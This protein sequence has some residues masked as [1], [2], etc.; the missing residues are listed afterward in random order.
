M[1]PAIGIIEVD[2][3]IT[4]SMPYLDTIKQFSDDDNI[5]AVVVRL[6]S[7][8][9]KVG[10]SQEIY[11]ALLKLKKKKPVVASFGALGASG[12]YYIACAAD[13]IYALPGTMTGS[14]GVIMEFFDASE[15][16]KRLGVTPNSI[17]AG[18]LKDAGSPFKPMSAREKDYFKA[19]VDDVHLQFIEAVCLRQE[20]E[21]GDGTATRGRQGVHRKAG[22][23]RRAR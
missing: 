5:K 18:T 8:G 10:P 17:T 6:D 13:T 3:I 11:S 21:N 4:E 1:K 14:I 20:A 19:L 12:A 23:H 22:M 15:G 2:G 7:P 9:G 16:L